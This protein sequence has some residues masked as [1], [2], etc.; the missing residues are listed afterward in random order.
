M[1]TKQKKM[2]KPFETQQIAAY[3]KL[4]ASGIVY[5]GN[6]KKV[7]RAYA[8]AKAQPNISQNDIAET[9]LNFDFNAA[10]SASIPVNNTHSIKDLVENLCEKY[11]LITVDDE[12]LGEPRLAGTRL[13]VSNVLTAF[14]MYDSIE[15]IIDEYDG[16]YSEKQLKEAVEFA[17]DFLDSFYTS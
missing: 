7:P 6:G 13:A 14:T 12:V 10:L 3:I 17:R 2:S 9:V 5:A 4:D 1:Q 11:P 16:R 15:E 8:T